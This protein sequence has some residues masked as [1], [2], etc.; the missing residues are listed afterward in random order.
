MAIDNIIKELSNIDNYFSEEKLPEPKALFIGCVLLV[1]VFAFFDSFFEKFVSLEIRSFVYLILFILWLFFWLYN[2]LHLP[3]VKKGMVGVVIAIYSENESERKKLKNDFISA[4]K[5]DL[6]Q[7]NLL[8]F[9]D[10]IFL[11]NHYCKKLVIDSSDDPNAYLEDLTKKMR[12]HFFVWGNIKKRSDGDEG[13]K[14]F[15][16]FQGYVVHKP[17]S[18]NLSNQISI[19]F[20]RVLPKEINFLENRSFRGFET[21]AALVSL[22][23]K[24]VIGLAAFVSHD[25]I[26]A[27]KLHVGLKDKFN[28]LRPLPVHLQHIR[29]R[30][31]ILIS[32]EYLWISRWYHSKKDIPNLKNNLNKSILEN[33]NNYAAWLFKAIVD[34]SIDE[35]PDEAL[36]SVKMAQR[37]AKGT[38]E[39]VYSEA[40]LYFWKGNY[41]SALKMCQKIKNQ[42]YIN[43]S[44]T[45]KEVREFNLN[46]LEKNPNKIQIYFFM[47]YLS[48]FKD[49]NLALAFSD[50]EKFEEMADH[51]MLFLKQRSSTY[52]QEIK[53]KMKIEV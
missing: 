28:E 35:N 11:Q 4:L 49:N 20:S 38:F 40:F 1:G 51:T 22:A 5:K 43:E 34:F 29:N 53:R 50:F 23:A 37:Y 45:V 2:R 30:I 16:S 21:S 27:L 26:M 44:L 13:E 31:P 3:K 14:Y 24:Y 48:Y 8:N 36:S 32:D 46:L 17:I 19:D 25:P 18:K 42:S 47:G 12:A 9:A 41:A 7:E 39:Y 52:L 15:I 33:S 10:V 6:R